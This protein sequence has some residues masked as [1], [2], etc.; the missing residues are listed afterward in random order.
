M[1]KIKLLAAVAIAC[2]FSLALA[3]HSSDVQTVTAS[4]FK[5]VCPH[6]AR[7]E[8]DASDKK[9]VDF[10]KDIQ[11]IFKAKC[12]EC[13]SADKDLASLRLDSK[14]TAFK[15][16]D[17]GKVIIPGKSKDSLLIQRITGSEGGLRMPPGKP[18]SDAE[19][20]LIRKWIDQ[21]ANW[22]DP[23]PDQKSSTSG[24]TAGSI[25]FARDVLPVLTANCYPCHS[26]D[27]PKGGLH[28]DNRE[29]ALKG[30]VSGPV[31]I[32]GNARDSTLLHRVL[33]LDG[34][35]RMPFGRNPL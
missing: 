23:K 16:G 25:D 22:P 8:P 27:T 17:S 30:G 11:P 4:E 13:H 35:S 12:Y 19:I 9:K 34:K 7:Q 31:I 10:I 26:G 28:L 21:G 6:S 33:G 5:S 18:L 20:E 14:E 29:M 1:N 15:G 3:S 32:P 2:L 24:Q